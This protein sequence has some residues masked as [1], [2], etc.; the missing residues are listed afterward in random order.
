MVLSLL[1]RSRVSNPFIPYMPIYESYLV[2]HQMGSKSGRSIQRN[3]RPN[4]DRIQLDG[5]LLPWWLG[6][7]VLVHSALQ[8]DGGML[9]LHLKL[10][11]YLSSSLWNFAGIKIR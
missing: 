2:R 8:A 3:Q 10:S 5:A 6:I 4:T 11:S 9:I 7:L 1:W